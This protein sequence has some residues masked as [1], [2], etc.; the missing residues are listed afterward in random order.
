MFFPGS[1]LFSL[2]HFSKNF[3]AI[4]LGSWILKKSKITFPL[5]ESSFELKSRKIKRFNRSIARILIDQSVGRL[6]FNRFL[7]SSLDHVLVV[8]R[9]TACVMSNSWA[10]LRLFEA[11]QS[12]TEQ[13]SFHPL[14]ARVKAVWD[15]PIGE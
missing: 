5:N 6:S 7:R 12:P 2:F 14:H 3:D 15:I 1:Q 11:M 9:D 13:Y 10:D 8:D 4:W